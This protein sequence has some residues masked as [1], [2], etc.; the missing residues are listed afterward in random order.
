[1][2]M[3]LLFLFCVPIVAA[4]LSLLL[5]NNQRLLERIALIASLIETGIAFVVV[6]T[7][8]RLQSYAYSTHLIVDSLGALLIGTTA[9]VGVFA[10]IYS[11]GYL[12][13]EIK[14]EIIDPVRLMQYYVLLHLFQAAMFFAILTAEPILMWI[15]IEATTLSTAFLINFYRK[16]SAVEAAWKYLIINSLGL[17]LA[18]FGTLVFMASAGHA[19]P[20][21]LSNWGELFAVA[22][23]LDPVVVKIAFVFLLIGYGTK[24]GLVP[25]HTWKPDAYSKAPT[26]VIALFS[27]V[28]MNVAFLPILRFK[29]IVD[30]A[31]GIAFTQQL[32]LF[33]GFI[34]VVVA[35]LL[36]FEQRNYK[37]LLA[38][39]SIE[40]AGL[41]ALGFGFGG[42]GTIAALLHMVYHALVK[43]L[44]FFSIGNVFLKFSSTKMENIRGVMSALPLTSVLLLIGFVGVVGMPPFGVFLTEMGILTA[45]M[46]SHPILVACTILA[47]VI[48]F[49]GFFKVITAM[50]FGE[51]PDGMKKGEF[52][53][54][55]TVPLVVLACL[56]VVMS[57]V[58]PD[59]LRE[60][61]MR[62]ASTLH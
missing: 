22:A 27:G 17:L 33:F 49:I 46:A 16:A 39:S 40:H 53:R 5:K 34:S 12:R 58:I 30:Q 18:L 24:V 29:T 50:L 44:L 47:L 7:V 28:L 20:A 38:F 36:M 6:N 45:G 41:I 37:R 59:G 21:S 54:W 1:M 32:L 3:E 25:M 55:T 51:I 15:A 23:S 19:V 56:F 62:S 26:P 8:I 10:T 31:L 4:L 61:I 42:L 13:R 14:K 52:S 11:I 9:V 2:A 57:F 60:L 43:S 48:A 35:S